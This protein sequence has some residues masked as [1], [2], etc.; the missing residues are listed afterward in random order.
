[1]S[2]HHN[3]SSFDNNQ[4]IVEQQSQQPTTTT[5]TTMLRRSTSFEDMKMDSQHM[6]LF[7]TTVINNNNNKNDHKLN[8][9]SFSTLPHNSKI[10]KQIQRQF[11]MENSPNHH[12]HPSATI[13]PMSQ[14]LID[15]EQM[16]MIAANN[17]KAYSTPNSPMITPFKLQQS[18][19]HPSPF[20]SS[21]HPNNKESSSGFGVNF[22]KK[23][24]W[25]KKSRRAASAPELGERIFFLVFFSLY[26][27]LMKY[28]HLH[29]INSNQ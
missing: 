10:M 2:N 23:F 15:E 28:H 12:H 22:G 26:T 21:R 11:E 1:M 17:N 24:C 4:N 13:Y 6:M 29:S 3:A 9:N 25:L 8:K 16:M 18:S 27:L 14:S 20:S 5:T 19:L 7:D